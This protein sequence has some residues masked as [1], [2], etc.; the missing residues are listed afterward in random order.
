[1][2]K[3]PAPLRVNIDSHPSGILIHIATERLFSSLESAKTR[4]CGSAS[5]GGG[6][7]ASQFSI[8]MMR[9]ATSSSGTMAP[10]SLHTNLVPVSSMTSSRQPQQFGLEI[11]VRDEGKARHLRNRGMPF[12]RVVLADQEE[13]VLP[14]A[15]PRALHRITVRLERLDHSGVA[16]SHTYPQTMRGSKSKSASDVSEVLHSSRRL[17]LWKSLKS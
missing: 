3:T 15:C 11:A 16:R 8:S 5:H 10:H 2:I 6:Q 14:H 13:G 9:R 4:W 7:V 12:G 1:M 17:R